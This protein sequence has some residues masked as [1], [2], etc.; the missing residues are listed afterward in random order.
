MN[1]S[2]PLSG[3]F[4]LRAEPRLDERGSFTRI[5]SS[6]HFQELG[7]CTDFVEW[8]QSHNMKAHT[9]RGVHW[10]DPPEIKMVHCV[11]GAIFDVAVDL[12]RH[13]PSFGRHYATILSAENCDILYIPQGFAHGFQTL[14][15]ASTVFYHISQA[16]VPDGAC[17]VRWNDPALAIEWP[18]PHSPIMSK[19]DETLP[20]LSEIQVK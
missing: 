18:N 6:A 20:L 1:F 9:L 3:L 7:L 15:E 17:G 13:S 12:R 16:Y 19:K 4:H 14:E 10:Q 2:E 5:F 8:S 11:R